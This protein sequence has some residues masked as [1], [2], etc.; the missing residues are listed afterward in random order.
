MTHRVRRSVA[1][2]MVAA[3]IAEVVRHAVLFA[4]LGATADKDLFDAAW[5]IPDLMV[6]ILAG[7]YLTM[8]LAPPTGVVSGADREA[9]R[10]I[11]AVVRV[12]S[13]AMVVPAAFGIALSNQLAGLVFPRVPDTVALASLMRVAFAAGLL[14][15]LGGVLATAAA[16]RR[17]VT[18]LA[19][20]PG[21][22]LLGVVVGGIVADGP[23]SYAWGRLG[24]SAAGLVLAAVMAIRAGVVFEWT[25]PLAHRSL[26]GRL[27][28]ARPAIATAVLFGSG[29]VWIRFAGQFT[30]EGSLAAIAAVH[31]LVVLAAATIGIPGMPPSSIVT[32]SPWLRAA[33]VAA[34]RVVITRS[35][36]VAV[37]VG[38]LARPITHIAYRWGALS[39]EAAEVMATLL[40]F[41]AMAI[42]AIATA[43]LY[44][45]VWA[46]RTG[47][48]TITGLVGAAAA[49]AAAWAGSQTL[50]SSGVVLAWVGWSAVLTIPAA[51]A[52]HRASD[53]SVA[54]H[55]VMSALAAGAAG[56]VTTFL[57]G[58]GD[59]LGVPAPLVVLVATGAAVATWVWVGRLI[60]LREATVGAAR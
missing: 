10:T 40:V 11:T 57:A 55:L 37:V 22:H 16:T 39:S 2:L 14:V 3:P 46:G 38:S 59:R 5:V 4:G 56:V 42:P 32:D 60:G 15:A 23:D 51:V 20:M 48:L 8:A 52:W 35:L 17:D 29:T 30:G 25:T 43:P 58:T 33:T 47:P 36:L 19:W 9:A 21:V 26:P 28:A 31:A 7:P 54:S 53:R 6:L 49:A 18:W 27:R 44:L 24:G 34:V 50:G 12:V 1:G 45:R 13:L 41:G